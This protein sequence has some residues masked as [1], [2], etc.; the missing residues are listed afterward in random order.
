MDEE[1]IKSFLERTDDL[2]ARL[3]GEDKETFTWVVCG[4]NQCAKL[5][6]ETEQK[7]EEQQKD[8]LEA[9]IK[10]QERAYEIAK[11]K[12]QQKKFMLWLEE[13]S[14]KIYRDGGLQQKIYKQI[15]Q[16]SKEM[17]GDNK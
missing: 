7:V 6:K 1:E 17:L 11:M 15:L 13:E 12:E 10:K 5:L 8:Y 16:K 2:G 14:K 9:L 3:T 4:Y